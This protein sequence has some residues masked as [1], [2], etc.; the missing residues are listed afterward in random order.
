MYERKRGPNAPKID[1]RDF[2]ADPAKLVKD[3]RMEVELNFYSP[4]IP[5]DQIIKNCYDWVSANIKR[6]FEH[7]TDYWKFPTETFFSREGDCEDGTILL[8]NM[9]LANKI[10][11]KDVAVAILKTGEEFH[12][13][14]LYQ[15]RRVL[16][17]THYC[18]GWTW[19]N[20]REALWYL[21]TVDYAYT[22]KE[23]LELFD[24]DSANSA[25]CC[26]TF[27]RKNFRDG[28]LRI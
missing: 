8:A 23:N 26:R 2:L 27:V 22:T 18:N 24:S 10:P 16:D 17:W 3:V 7:G 25:S 5:R 12:A 4:Q 28:L 9:L 1:V 15:W 6:S 20:V 19:K 14:V 21:W 13:V 11:P